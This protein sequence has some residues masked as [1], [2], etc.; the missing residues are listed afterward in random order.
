VLFNGNIDCNSWARKLL[1]GMNMFHNFDNLRQH[2]DSFDNFFN[3]VWYMLNNFFNIYNLL[4]FCLGRNLYG[5]NPGFIDY[6]FSQDFLFN[7]LFN[8]SLGL[9]DNFFQLFTNH[10]YADCL[11]NFFIDFFQLIKDTSDRH[12]SVSLD[13]NW[14]LFVVNVVL[15]LVNFNNVGLF[16]DFR[17]VDRV[18][19]VMVL[20]N[21]F[22]HVKINLFRNFNCVLDLNDLFAQNLDLFRNFNVFDSLWTRNLLDNLDLDGFFDLYLND[23][24]DCDCVCDWFLDCCDLRYFDNLLD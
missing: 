15:W 22:I 14:N 3:V 24:W 5:L 4:D 6:N 23:F 18:K 21:D 12:V 9:S 16:N 10:L 20:V 19:N 7:F 17:N 11:F 2:Y 8:V 13:F 1:N